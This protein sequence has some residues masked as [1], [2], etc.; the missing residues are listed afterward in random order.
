[1]LQFGINLQQKMVFCALKQK[2]QGFPCLIIR[3]VCDYSDSHKHEKWQGYI[4]MAAAAYT[5][6]L[7]CRITPSRVEA[8]KRVGDTLSGLSMKA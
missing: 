3:G 8:E 7:L 5:K 6:D 4:A 2:P 1:M